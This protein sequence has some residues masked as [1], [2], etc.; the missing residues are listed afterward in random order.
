MLRGL[1]TAATA[2]LAKSRQMDV[3]TNNLVN[4]E[5]TGF[6]QDTL[7]TTPFKDVLMSRLNDPS[8]YQYRNVGMHNFGMHIDQ[9]YTSFTPGALTET[10]NYTDLALPGEGFFVVEYTPPA[11]ARDEEADEYPEPEL[12][13]TRA[14]NFAV[15]GDGYLVTPNGCY[16]QGQNGAIEVGTSAFAVDGEG[17]ISVD[18]QVIDTLRVVRFE[19]TSVLR[20]AGDNLLRVYT[21]VDEY[22]D[23]V[24][25]GEEPE[26][27]TPVIRQGFLEASNVDIARETVRMM[28]VFRSYEINQ[29]IIQ[30]Y[31]QSLGQTVNDIARF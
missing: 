31:D 21:T 6:R 10:G 23:E 3:V 15:D 20:K 13:Y 26:D 27:I 5:T 22:G 14:G 4:A 11:I 7:V 29:R 28:E 1:Y 9:V 2:M 8:V 16:V 19:D 30:L 24:P 12:R 18:G 25:A 17:N